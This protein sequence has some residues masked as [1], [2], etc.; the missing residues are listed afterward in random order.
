[1]KNEEKWMSW[2]MGEMPERKLGYCG[3]PTDLST[4]FVL[5]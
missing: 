1:M 3:I 2:K 4:F 5:L